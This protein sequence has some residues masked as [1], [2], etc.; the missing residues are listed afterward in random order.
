V[1]EYA[2]E[3][4]RNVAVVG[5]QECGKTVLS[6]ALLFSAGA[7]NRLGKIEDG[8]TTMDAAPE[9]IERKI[10]IQSALAFCEH[11]GTKINLVDTPGY[12]DFVGDVLCALDVVESAI[13]P[14]RSDAGVEVGTE[15]VWEFIQNRGL[16]AILVVNKLD[17]E[18][19]DFDHCVDQARGSFGGNVRVFQLPIGQGDS[20]TGVVDLVS[21]KAYEFSKDGK[22]TAREVEIPADLKDRAES[23]RRELMETAAEADE[24]H[25]EKYLETEN[26]DEADFLSGLATG[27]AAGDVYPVYCMSSLLNMGSLPLLDAIV[28]FLPAPTHRAKIV[29]GDKEIKADVSAPASAYVFKNTTDSHVGD[30]LFLRVY[31]GALSGGNDIYNTRRDTGE[32]LGQLYAVQGKHREEVGRLPAGDMGAVVKLKSTRIR[33][34]LCDKA[35]KVKFAVTELPSPS[36]FAAISRAPKGDEDKMGTGLNRLHDEDPAFEV[37]VDGEVKQT[38]ISGQGE[39]HLEV[40]VGRLK[41]RFGVEVI[42]DKP[43]IPYKETVKKTAEA[44]GK[45]KKQTGG[46][47]QYGDVHI[48]LEPLPRGSDFEFVDGIVGGVVPGKFIPAVEKGIVGAM[49][50]GVI[51]GYPVVDV[52]ATLFDGSYHTVDSSEQAFKMAGSMAFKK[53]AQAAVPVLLEPIINVRVKVPEEFMGDVMG[54]L[55]GRRGKIQGME[56]EGRFNVIN[57]QVPLAELYRYSTHLRSMTQGRGTHSREFSHYEEIPHDVAQ[58]VIDEAKKAKEAEK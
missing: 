44:Q 15:K 43:R 39:L 14:I 17:K 11:N 52:K 46:R 10:S 5:H 9:E 19:A 2:P 3:N 53:A 29:D 32:R 18:H 1:K 16:S 55:S 38:V 27:V 6:E 22:G 30:M 20:F 26:L 12:E 8:N 31:S 4:I 35:H 24:A 49:R 37:K 45:Y 13:V 50:D 54:D 48:R 47:G 40:V 36:I 56:P 21:N 33:D 25:M 51:A 28:N 58:K 7:I 57:A 23:L 34:T 42:L 41:S